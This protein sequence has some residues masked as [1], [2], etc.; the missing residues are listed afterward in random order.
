V[1]NHPDVPALPHS[2]RALRHRLT[3][4]TAPLLPLS[5]EACEAHSYYLGYGDGRR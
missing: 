4:P 5:R 3:A 2:S 1:P